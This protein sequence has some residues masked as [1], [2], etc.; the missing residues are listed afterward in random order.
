MERRDKF[1]NIQELKT[2]LTTHSASLLI[3]CLHNSINSSLSVLQKFLEDA[4][5]IFNDDLLLS[6]Q[7]RKDE[8]IDNLPHGFFLLYL[9]HSVE[10]GNQY[11]YVFSYRQVLSISSSV[12]NFNRNNKKPKKIHKHSSSLSCTYYNRF[13]VISFNISFVRTR[14]NSTFRPGI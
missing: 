11:L 2:Y 3:V 1:Y 13:A 6:F 4:P 5:K 8:S 9:I 12:F 10:T 7:F 14:F